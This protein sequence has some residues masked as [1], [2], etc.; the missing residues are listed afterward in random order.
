MLSNYWNNCLHN[1]ATRMVTF[2]LTDSRVSGSFRMHLF[3]DVGLTDLLVKAFRENTEDLEN[4]DAGHRR[5]YMGHLKSIADQVKNTTLTHTNVAQ[6]LEC[7]SI[8]WHLISAPSFI[9]IFA[10]LIS[11]LSFTH[12]VSLSVFFAHPLL[13]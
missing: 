5:G 2:I 13:N 9:A 11:S 3:Q 12:P 6:F 4:E 8:A 1:L 7:K 10:F